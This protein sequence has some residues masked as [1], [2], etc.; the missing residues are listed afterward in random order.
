MYIIVYLPEQYFIK[1]WFFFSESNIK[2]IVL[3]VTIGVLAALLVLSVGVIIYQ[4]R[5]IS[6]FLRNRRQTDNALGPAHSQNYDNV[7]SSE[8]VHVYTTLDSVK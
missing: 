2:E 5:K 8:D 4:R 6:G 1:T 7:T 3:Y